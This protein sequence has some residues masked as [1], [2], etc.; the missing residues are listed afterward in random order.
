MRWHSKTQSL[1]A[2]NIV[3]NDSASQEKSQSNEKVT[4]IA[5]FMGVV[6]SIGGFMFGY[7]R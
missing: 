7:V 5:C 3:N 6:A 1:Q 4:F 2:D